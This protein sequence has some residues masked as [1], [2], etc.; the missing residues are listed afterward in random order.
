M[1]RLLG[2]KMVQTTQE[3]RGLSHPMKTIAYLQTRQVWMEW[4]WLHNNGKDEEEDE[5][6]DTTTETHKE[7]KTEQKS[8]SPTQEQSQ[9]RTISK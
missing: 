8:S 9:Q 6:N 2:R 3:A 4:T 7:K 5:D 1:L